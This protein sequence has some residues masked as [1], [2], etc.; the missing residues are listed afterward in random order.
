MSLALI[1]VPPWPAAPSAD[2]EPSE[3]MAWYAAVARWAPSKHNT[4]PWRFVVRGNALEVWT[5][6]QR[7]LPDSDPH[8]RELTIAC[9]AALHLACVA[10]RALGFQPLVTVLPDGVGGLLGRLVET[11]PWAASPQD[12]EFLALVPRRRTDRGPLNSAVLPGSVPF[13][14]QSAAAVQGASL[15]LVS[16]P[17]DRATL[18]RL[19]ERADRLLVQRG[20]IDRELQRWSREAGDGRADGVP[21]DRTRGAAASYRAEFVQRD[22]SGAHPRPRHDR[23]GADHPIIGVICTGSDREADWITAGRALASVLLCAAQ[24]GADSSYL[25]QPVEEPAIRNELRTMLDLPGAAQVI[26]RI[27]VGGNVLP[28]PRRDAD[29]VTIRTSSD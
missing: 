22:F 29:E 19:V 5:D 7:S 12:L 10:A 13:L 25:N 8:R 4:Q 1:P 17:G 2:A 18:V 27:G 16:T 23:D 24:H 6:P 9:G 14:L 15:R 3:R 26:L 28:T 20:D 21:T 11:G